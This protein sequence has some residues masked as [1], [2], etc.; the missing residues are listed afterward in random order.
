MVP[1]YSE[2]ATNDT[3]RYLQGLFNVRKYIHETKAV[4]TEQEI[5]NYA[6]FKRLQNKVD[7]VLGRSKYNKVDLGSI[8]AFMSKN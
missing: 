2:F 3:L 6:E 1:E 8:F 5:C 7:L 4:K